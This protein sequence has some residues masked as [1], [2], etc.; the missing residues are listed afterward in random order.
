LIAAI[1]V[2]SL[3]ACEAPTQRPARYVDVGDWQAYRAIMFAPL[4][5]CPLT[6][7]SVNVR[8]AASFGDD[9]HVTQTEVSAVDHTELESA[10]RDCLAKQMQ[11]ATMTAGKA[12]SM[13]T[14]ILFSRVAETGKVGRPFDR[15]AAAAEIGSIRFVACRA[16]GGPTGGGH[17]QITFAQDGTATSAIV[18]QPPFAGTDVG[19]C[20]SERFMAARVP[21]FLGNPVK[22]GKS[23]T[24]DA[25]APGTTDL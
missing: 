22:V 17:I 13:H 23:F 9:G 24:I 3:L 14:E 4:D 21:P 11:A 5:E 6:A 10:F 20:I 8:L 7:T 12:R 25:P 19:E 2:L 15:G 1:A 16:P 18:D